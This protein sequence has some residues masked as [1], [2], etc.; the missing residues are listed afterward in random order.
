MGWRVLV[1][2]VLSL[3]PA[4]VLAQE[5]GRL[6]GPEITRALTARVLGYDDGTTQDFLADG[7]T[8][9]AGGW[10]RWRVEGD[11]YCSAWPPSDVWACYLV[12]R[13]ARGLDIRFT[14]EGGAVTVGRYV[15]LQ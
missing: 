5:W 13:E 14:G 12:E 11:R 8:L 6:S 9:A 3:G 7:R 2:A 10:G 4:P 15:D 1:L